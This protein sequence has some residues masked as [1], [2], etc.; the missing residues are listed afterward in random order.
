MRRLSFG[1]LFGFLSLALPL[2][3]TADVFELSNGDTIDA[4]VIEE[5]EDTIVVEHPQLG[6]VVL[7]RSA[8]KPPALPNPGLFG[9][10]FLEGWSRN[11]G[12]GVSGSSGNS[13]DASVNGS[14]A[15]SR[16]ANRYRAAFNSSY[17]YASQE[18]EPTTNEFFANYQHDFLF[19]DSPFYVFL[20]TRY[21][22]DEFQ[23]W[24]D[25]IT[26]SGGAGYT[27]L[28]RETLQLRGELGAGFSR[29]WGTEPGW[30][31]EGLVGLVLEW[32]PVEGQQLTADLTYYPDFDD[33]GEYRALANAA[34]TVAITQLDGLSLKLGIKNEYDSDQPGDNNN[35]KYYGNLVY[36][37]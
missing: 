29:S 31:P 6:R 19:Q 33:L 2:S 7:Q 25:R 24:R 30:R 12:A 18:G 4:T 21:Q 9:T 32:T 13:S 28:D 26:G 23:A 1:L 5:T 17:F 35:L 37:F 3:A 8:L 11:I 27:L 16:S 20:Q 22:H 14:I 15:L 34:Y 36:D 10:Q